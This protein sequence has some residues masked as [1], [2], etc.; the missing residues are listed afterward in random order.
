[1]TEIG[2]HITFEE[3]EGEEL[4]TQLNHMVFLIHQWEVLVQVL[5]RKD[6]EGIMIEREIEVLKMLMDIMEVS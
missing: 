1:M 4:N 2:N 6:M 3:E 5:E